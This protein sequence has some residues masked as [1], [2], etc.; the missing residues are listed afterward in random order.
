MEYTEF[1][2]KIKKN[3]I[4]LFDYEM[5]QL[6]YQLK[7]SNNMKGGGNN[8]NKFFNCS[9]KKIIIDFYKSKCLDLP[10]IDRN[11]KCI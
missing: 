3:N 5:R 1:V 4:T 9:N 8:L 6:Y 2:K 10:F 11:Y 7:N